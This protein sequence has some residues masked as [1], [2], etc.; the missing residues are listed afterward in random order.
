[1]LNI[2]KLRR[3]GENY[4]LNSVARGVED[5]YLGSGEAPG[6][7]LASGAASLG[8]SGQ[9]SDGDLRDVLA[10]SIPGS[11]D[12]AMRASKDRVPGFDL[13]FRAPKSVAL[14]HA[15]GDKEA[16]N[17]V[18]SA[19]DV[20]VQGALDYLERVASHG[21]RGSGGRRHIASKGFIAAAFRHRT[22]RA[23]D[24]LLHTH[25]LVANLILGADSKL[26][27][28]DA[29]HLYTHA[30]T[31]GFL[32]QAQLRAELTRRIGVEWTPVQNGTAD[33][34]GIPRAAIEAFSTRRRE[35]EEEEP[36]SARSAQ[37]AALATRRAKDYGINPEDL[38][39]RWQERAEN[40]GLSQALLD[41]TLKR[42]VVQET[43]RSEVA[44]IER[45]LAGP[46]GVT[47]QVSTFTR[48]E[49]LQGFCSGLPQGADIAAIESMA[50][51]F[52]VSEAA[53]PLPGRSD[54]A[55][56]H[57]P[58]DHG[59]IPARPNEHR[60]TTQEMIATERSVIDS[61]L[62]RRDDGVGLAS[63][64]HVEA[65]LADRPDLSA[66]QQEM[67]RR[68]TSSGYG[69]EVVVGKAG[70]GKTYALDAARAAWEG[71][72]WRV[73]GC[74]LAAR[75]SQELEAGSRIRSFTLARLLTD[76]ESDR[77]GGLP[78]DCVVV[79]DEAAMVPTRDM[80]RLF[81]HAAAAR[82][83]VVLVGDDG[84]LPEIDAGGAFKGIK[85]RLGVI[86]LSNV[87]RQPW[88]WEREALDAIREGDAESA[89]AAY[90]DHDRVVITPKSDKT[91]S[92]LI[93]DWWATQDTET[94][95][96]MLA[97]RRSDVDDLNARARAVMKSKGRLGA[98]SLDVGGKSFAV[99]DRVITRHRTR[100]GVINGTLGIVEAIE[101]SGG[102]A[103]RMNDGSHVTIER[104]DLEAGHLT[105][106]YALTGHKAQGMTT[107]RVFVLADETLYREWAY[108]T[109]SRGRDDNRLYVIA[110]CDVER[111]ELGGQVA[112][113]TD[114]LPDVTR[115]LSRSRAK[116]LAL[117]A[118]MDTRSEAT[119]E[120]ELS[121][122]L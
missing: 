31:A 102:L 28:V 78:S 80:R 12:K 69:V 103:F 108:A 35:I 122:E 3:G 8:L 50:D 7:W 25:V 83:K 91:R 121:L 74:A 24:P 1:V 13:T 101:P 41:A 84:Q 52:L 59:W 76:A 40:C 77:E 19:H 32:Y 72:G 23:G 38:L 26:G 71:S 39:P 105:H 110:G 120:L 92:R 82:A 58:R 14:L 48:R 88:G 104:C 107:D 33:I 94:P 37:V 112:R 47:A 44:E 86:E 6:Y 111:D 114:P 106:A 73:I 99:G 54:G 64:H 118:A 29:R 36:G 16:A 30:K 117:D 53:I 56:D 63:R 60:Y 79:V 90:S 10:G 62:K 85:R 97:A 27:A 15:L 98:Q 93:E 81:E 5:Y 66:D 95:A 22:S 17:E 89:L 2:G 43:T 42:S 75:A 61:A 100:G 18:V 51:T 96:M 4:Y 119:F 87:R 45:S 9:V 46:T 21:R 70:T 20:A 109:M 113:V 65:S 57:Q 115:A 55:H 49:T 11:N 68:L 116:E 67:V 34:E